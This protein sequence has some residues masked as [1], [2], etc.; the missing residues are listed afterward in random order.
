MSFYLRQ[1]VDFDKHNEE[2]ERVWD[3][4]H[5]GKPYRVPT[6]VT[7]S[8]TNFFCN[9]E[10]NSTRWT[11]KDF[12]TNPQAQIEAQLAYQKYKRWNWTCDSPM[13]PPD[14]WNLAVDF[15]NSYEA[16][17]FGCPLTYDGPVPDTLEILAGD[18]K[19]KLYE[20]EPP[21]PVR[22]NLLGRA[23]EFLEYMHDNCK[24]LEFE[25]KP[26]HPPSGVPGEGTDGPF[27]IACKLRGLTQC[28]IDMLEDDKY[29]HDLMT[30]VTDNTIRRIKGLREWR[31]SRN[32]AE[33]PADGADP[34]QRGGFFIAD[35]A[36]AMLSVRQYEE[37]VFPYHLRLV[38]E[39]SDGKS[40]VN[41]THLCGNATHLFKF[42]RDNLRIHSFDTGF[43]VDFGWVRRELGPEVTIQGGVTIM[44][45]QSGPP[46]AIRQ[47]V[48]RI[49]ASGIM[50]G[51]RFI[52]REANNL[53]PCTPVEHVA[54]FYHAGKEFGRY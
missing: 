19:M 38:N 4:Y 13:G 44:L 40:R 49:C 37:F 10:I 41:S 39:F 46:E 21:D 34:F 30:F 35:D 20:L 48:R 11:F 51:G 29:F 26:V 54:A 43:P 52:L 2:V 33:R 25:G 9:P 22:G 16:G 12:F 53:A 28:C 1:P 3:A 45:L 18:N 24:S 8:I 6:T 50:E 5:K 15:Q 42:L 17:W 32:P 31:W 27:T 23:V 36:I 7:G 14:A 47:E